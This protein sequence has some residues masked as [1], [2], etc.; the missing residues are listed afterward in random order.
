MMKRLLL[1]LL[2]TFAGPAFAQQTTTTPQTTMGAMT[3]Q[4]WMMRGVNIGVQDTLNAWPQIMKQFPGMTAVRLNYGVNMGAADPMADIITV[5]NDYT[6][7][8]VVVEIEDHT[9]DPCNV[10]LYTGWAQEFK[11]NALVYIEMPNEPVAD[12]QTTAQNQITLINA[13]RGAG[14]TNPIGVQPVGG[15]DFSNLPIVIAALG[16]NGLFVT[17]HIYYSGTDPNGGA[18]YVQSDL[19]QAKALGLWAVIDEFGNSMDGQSPDPQGNSVILAVIAVSEGGQAGGVFWAADNGNHPDG[20]DS[21]FMDPGGNQLTPV[22]TSMIQPWLWTSNGTTPAPGS[23]PTAQQTLQL[24]TIDSEVDGLESQ[25][26]AAVAQGAALA[27]AI[28]A[29]INKATAIPATPSTAPMAA[30]P[31]AVATNSQPPQEPA[32]QAQASA[33]PITLPPAAP[34]P[35]VADPQGLQDGVPPPS[36]NTALAVIMQQ[37]QATMVQAAQ[38]QQL[39]QSLAGQSATALSPPPS[40]PAVTPAAASPPSQPQQS[41]GGG[42]EGGDGGGDGGEGGD[43]GGDD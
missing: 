6:S 25:V 10:A 2:L 15:Y 16:T 21:A 40:P 22:G 31:P 11:G 4:P 39:L 19:Q 5:V 35:E 3:R 9:G 33:A 26:D 18:D 28:A 30:P 14:F 23:I 29:Q 24:N 36:V 7:A 32:V 17:P 41:V 13:V 38:E 27:K 34:T 42:S 20:T 12:A 43:G 8:G 37:L 1:G